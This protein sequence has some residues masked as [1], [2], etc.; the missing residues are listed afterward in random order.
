MYGYRKT[1]SNFHLDVD[2]CQILPSD[3]VTD[4]GLNVSCDL[5]W[6]GHI[7]LKLNKAM[8][9]LYTLK[10]ALPDRSARWVKRNM[11]N[12]CVM[13]VLLY[14]SP[15][16]FASRTNLKRLERFQRK[17]VKWITS[18]SF[19]DDTSYS[20]AL[21]SLNILPI[22]YRLLFNDLCL[23][24]SLIT[25]QDSAATLCY[26][27]ASSSYDTRRTTANIFFERPVRRAKTKQCFFV[28]TTSSANLL[29][30]RFRLDIT[31]PRLPFRRSLRA[32]LFSHVSS[33][34]YSY[35]DTYSFL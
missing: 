30:R 4:L 12:T 25:T 19:H 26:F 23:L 29:K 9:A 11:Y 31:M 3:A 13:S 5:N 24:N 20:S 28:R 33:F 34:K 22:S 18:C 2:N 15:C 27:P 6:D 8:S 16:W 10:H 32:L 17:A 35:L 21:S 7:S 1:S 14:A